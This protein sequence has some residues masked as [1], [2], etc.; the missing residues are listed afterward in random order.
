VHRLGFKYP[1]GVFWINAE[2]GI[3]SMIDDIKQAANIEID[4]RLDDTAQLSHIWQVLSQCGNVLIVLDNFLENEP[5]QPWLPPVTSIYTLVTT[6]RRDLAYGRLALDFMTNAEGLALLNSDKR[7]FGK[8]AETIVETLGG[9]PLALELT[10]HFLNLRPS[11]TIEKLSKKLSIK[12]SFTH[13]PI[14]YQKI[15]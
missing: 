3:S 13:Y 2:R 7:Q 1:G 5:L 14:F 8:E 10:R 9:L 12:V 6:R 4:P 15:R 11:L